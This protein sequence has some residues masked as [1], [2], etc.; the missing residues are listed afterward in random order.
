MIETNDFEIQEFNG[1]K[2][3]QHELLSKTFIE[4]RKYQ[5]ELY[6]DSFSKNTLV[7]LPTGLGKTTIS[8]LISAHN[9]NIN[10]ADTKILFLAPTKP[11]VSQHVSF[12]KKALNIPED[13]ITSYTGSTSPDKRA[14]LWDENK[15]LIATPQ[16]V[17][18]DL[19][20]DT[21]SLSN[22][23][24]LTIDECHRGTGKYSYVY[25]ANEYNK[26]NTEGIITA[27]SAS[28]GSTKNEILTICENLHL[29]NIAVKTEKDD[30]VK[31]YTHETN[32]EWKKISIPD[33]VHE[34]TE[35]L[36]KDVKAR[37]KALKKMGVAD[38]A[39]KNV[40]KGKVLSF[41]SKLSEMID[42]GEE[43]GYMGMSYYSELINLVDSINIIESQGSDEFLEYVNRRREESRSSGASK[44]VKRFVHSTNVK[45]AETIAEKMDDAHP[46]LKQLRIEIARTL[47]IDNGERVIVFTDSRNAANTIRDFLDDN[48]KVEKFIGQTNKSGD[49]GMTQSE[50]EDVLNRFRNGDIEVLIS[51]S[52]AEEGL[53]IPEV[54]L[55]VFYEPLSEAIRT[56]QRKGRTGRQSDGEVIILMS[57]NTN[58]EGKFWAFKNNEK[59]MKE[60]LHELESMEEDIINELVDTQTEI[61]NFEDGN[62]KEDNIEINDDSENVEI[63]VDSREL[64]SGVPKELKNINNTSVDVKTLDVG[65]YV[66][67]NRTVVERKSVQ[68]FYDSIV[69]DDRSIFKQASDMVDNYSRPIVIIEGESLYG[70]GR[71]VHPNAVK[72]VISSLAVDF[73][74][75]VLRTT[76]VDDT[77]KML[78]ITAKRE[79]EDNETTINPHGSKGK[80]TRDEQKEYIVSSVVDVGPVT[81]QKLLEE[82]ESV[83][84]VF[85]A[86]KEKLEQID[87]IGEV[88]A[89]QFED[90]IT[91]EYNSE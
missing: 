3:I 73:N 62:D 84:D 71:N 86:P 43:D 32:V 56:I 51:T 66:L 30:S 85:N 11:L 28:P 31:E 55:V 41:R 15:I 13:K 88:I 48:F 60:A 2:Y 19:I 33:G 42:R 76:D 54:D 40:S 65:D 18:N 27:M 87:G 21:I 68:D 53:D 38:S 25:I 22:V 37:M 35:L 57:K 79:Q 14:D 78:Q 34:I 1:E 6:N 7:C 44:A 52:V 8:L 90:I 23:T 39:T 9:M 67:S 83:R 58:E 47:G 61:D 82:F 5:T 77:A 91:E 70:A 10:S 80:Q 50:Q 45:K 72:A 49:D 24:H 75:S 81:A 64:R 12:Y 69:D 29:E 89:E 46:K 17:E 4:Y 59:K 74:I 26:Q 36:K 16:V 63:I 20:S